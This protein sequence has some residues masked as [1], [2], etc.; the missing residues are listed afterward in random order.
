MSGFLGRV[1]KVM[2]TDKSQEVRKG[3]FDSVTGK[4]KEVAGA[5][6]GKDDLV[7]EGQLQQAEARLRKDAVAEE[8]V[9]DVQQD[10]ARQQVRESAEEADQ[11]TRA[12]RTEA[13]RETSQVERERNGEHAAAARAA[14]VQEA[15]GREV[16][17]QEAG[18]LAEARLREA[19]RLAADAASIEQRAAA[20]SLRLQRE[21]DAADHQAAERRAETKN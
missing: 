3:L 8:A 21:A 16:A 18:E 7:E 6:S 9:A 11:R 19:Q 1:R 13:R 20:D 2:S 14:D 5:V 4:A 17:E 15:Q 10:E 12:S